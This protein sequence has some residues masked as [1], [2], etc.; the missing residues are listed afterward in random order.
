M[1]AVAWVRRA[2]YDPPM[3]LSVDHAPQRAKARYVSVICCTFALLSSA[4]VAPKLYSQYLA[5]RVETNSLQVRAGKFLCIIAKRPW[6]VCTW[7]IIRQHERCFIADDA[8]LF[9]SNVEDRR[10]IGSA[11]GRNPHREEHSRTMTPPRPPHV[12]QRSLFP[13]VW[14][15]FRPSS[16]SS[17][18]LPVQSA[19]LPT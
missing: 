11:A 13:P 17:P 19:S 7:I 18:P 8:R 6:A 15:P 14:L 16:L 9:T 4:D 1:P 2:L 5:E 10:N 3:R 12:W